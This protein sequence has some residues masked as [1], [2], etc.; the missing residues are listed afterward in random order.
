MKV[1]GLLIPTAAIEAA[2]EALT[3]E[4]RSEDVVGAIA[5]TLSEMEFDYGIQYRSAVNVR[6]ADRILQAARKE[7][8]IEHVGA[9]RWVSLD[10][11]PAL[12]GPG[13]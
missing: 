2:E 8:R 6:T 12:G 3:G 7:G 11:S 5:R 13:R 10:V 4:F 9:G 1:Q